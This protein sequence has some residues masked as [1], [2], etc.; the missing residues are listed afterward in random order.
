MV[1]GDFMEPPNSVDVPR[2]LFEILFKTFYIVM[3]PR[4]DTFV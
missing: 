3:W 1:F 2:L 4:I